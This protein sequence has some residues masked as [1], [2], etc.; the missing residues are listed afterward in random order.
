[1]ALHALVVR[2]QISHP[3]KC[4]G[5][6]HDPLEIKPTDAIEFNIDGEADVWEFDDSSAFDSC[7]F[8]RAK[9][10]VADAGNKAVAAAAGTETTRYFSSKKGM[11][12]NA[13]GVDEW[14]LKLQVNVKGDVNGNIV[15]GQDV[16]PSPTPKYLRKK[17]QGCDGVGKFNRRGGRNPR[18]CMTQCN[19]MKKASRYCY[20]YQYD[21]K[22]PIK[23]R[24]KLF[25]EI[26]G[27]GFKAGRA[28]SICYI[29]Q[30]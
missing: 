13:C 1:L 7:D 24:C 20:A 18:K 9:Q 14:P 4:C 17:K 30:N 3:W 5:I 10:I 26:R 6:K 15:T 22:K 19:R 29:R 16:S 11:L 2:A 28:S 23:R 25:T 8:N 12:G 27:Q 21:R